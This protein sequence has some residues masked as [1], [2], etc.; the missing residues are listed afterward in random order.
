MSTPSAKPRPAIRVSAVVGCVTLLSACGA[1]SEASTTPPPPPATPSNYLAVSP[2]DQQATAGQPVPVKPSLRVQGAN[3]APFAG[4]TVTF[5][6]GSGGGTA[7]GTTQVTNAS[8]IATV[9]DWVLGNSAGPNTMHVAVQGVSGTMTFAAQG[10]PGPAA[11]LVYVNGNALR[12]PQR[13]REPFGFGVQLVDQFGNWV[14][15]SGVT[16]TVGIASGGGTLV[17]NLAANTLSGVASFSDVVLR[18]TLGVRTLSLSAPGLTALTTPVE[19][20]AGQPDTVEIFAG[21]GQSAVVGT[22]VA[23]RPAVRLLDADKNPVPAADVRFMVTAGGGTL[24]GDSTSSD[25]TGIAR[26]GSWTLGPQAAVNSLRAELRVATALPVSFSAQG[27]AP[28]ARRIP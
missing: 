21:N 4:A 28:A 18:G 19:L 8:G 11:G 7:T 1:A 12:S 15:Q 9:G 6:V 25:A 13:N 10:R 2:M 22:A 26:V 17:G 23:V 14:T 20:L 16:V 27:V 24:A 3:N 5:S